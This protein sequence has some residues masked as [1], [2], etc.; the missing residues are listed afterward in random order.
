MRPRS[1]AATLRTGPLVLAGAFGLLGIACAAPDEHLAWGRA[2]RS[3]VAWR[4]G[5]SRSLT[6]GDS[7]GVMA[8]LIKRG[9]ATARMAGSFPIPLHPKRRKGASRTHAPNEGLHALLATYTS[10]ESQ[11]TLKS[12]AEDPIWVLA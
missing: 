1:L 12:N 9:R 4:E 11:R 6:Q 8:L 10:D 5:S 2:M 7:D 3:M